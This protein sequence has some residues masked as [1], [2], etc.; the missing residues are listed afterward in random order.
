M[1]TITTLKDIHCIYTQSIVTAKHFNFHSAIQKKIKIK[2]LYA[3]LDVK[4]I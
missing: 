2:I 3:S 1:N 4:L